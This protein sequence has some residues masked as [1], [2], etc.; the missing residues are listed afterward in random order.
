LDRIYRMEGR[1]IL[2]M[3]NMKA[4]EGRVL[5]RINKI[6]GIFKEDSPLMSKI[7]A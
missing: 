7:E 2:D 5:D 3:R 4:D 1:L 6:Y